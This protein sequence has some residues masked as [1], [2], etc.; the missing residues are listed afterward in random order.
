MRLSL[1]IVRPIRALLAVVPVLI[2][3]SVHTTSAAWPERAIT[4][5]VPFPEGGAN[6]LLGRLLAEELEPK[7][8]QKVIVQNREGG[9]GNIGLT[10]AA[11]AGSSGY[12]L[13]V[14][15]NALLINP[16]ID[17]SLIETAYDP[18]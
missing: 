2:A 9:V 14:T 11:H 5:I 18:I 13:L 12:T 17:P 16:A 3:F 10:E 15:T 4:I 7:L 1:R 6:D 8:G